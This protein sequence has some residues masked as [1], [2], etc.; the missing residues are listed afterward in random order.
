MSL[1]NG[2]I[3]LTQKELYEGRTEAR[4][5]IRSVQELHAHNMV[6]EYAS[7]NKIYQPRVEKMCDKFSALGVPEEVIETAKN[8]KGF[9]DILSFIK[10]FQKIFVE[11]IKPEPI[12][13]TENTHSTSLK[14]EQSVYKFANFVGDCYREAQIALGKEST[15]PKVIKI[16]NILKEK[17]GVQTA[18]F[19][20]DLEMAQKVLKAVELAHSKN[21]VIPND[22]I[23]S[24]FTLNRG[25][26]LRVNKNGEER[27]SVILA[28]TKTQNCIGKMVDSMHD[29]FPAELRLKYDKWAEFCGFKNGSSTDSP[30][31]IV[32]H[33]MMHQIH[34]DLLAFRVKKVPE[35]FLPVV[36]KL[37]RY[38]AMCEK[39]CREIYAELA[40]KKLL[41]GLKKDEAELFDYLNGVN[42]EEDELVKILSGK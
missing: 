38:S 9:G 22:F 32:T 2:A 19:N 28:P 7:S 3:N 15:N 16:E 5:I 12:K 11:K 27:K 34:P 24:D 33:E 4:R 26:C 30:L 40:T 41:S 23:V 10:N 18:L 39:D 8:L 42:P 1:I 21:I 14:N 20:N 35:K 17:Y 36:R 37:S 13:F 29:M 31:H 25:A 6:S